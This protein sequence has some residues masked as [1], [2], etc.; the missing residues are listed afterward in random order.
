MAFRSLFIPLAAVVVL[1]AASGSLKAEGSQL[2]YIKNGSSDKY[3]IYISDSTWTLGL[4]KVWKVADEEPGDEGAG[5]IKDKDGSFILEPGETYKLRVIGSQSKNLSYL[6]NEKLET[7]VKGKVVMLHLSIE[8]DS[9]MAFSSSKLHFVGCAIGSHF[10]SLQDAIAQLSKKLPGIGDKIKNSPLGSFTD[11][12]AVEVQ[13]KMDHVTA[14][15]ENFQKGA[16]D[17]PFLWEID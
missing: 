7:I 9:H 8:K 1:A 11:K 15:V 6:K 13:G 5:V 4:V 16:Q 17:G 14:Q 12:P 10:Y 2:S 3:K